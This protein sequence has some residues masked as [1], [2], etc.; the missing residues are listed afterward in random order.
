MLLR[1]EIAPAQRVSATLRVRLSPKAVQIVGEALP[2]KVKAGS[3]VDAQFSV[4]FQVAAAWLDGRCNWQSYERLGGADID[5]LA[6]RIEV[7]VDDNLAVAGAV[8][9]VI[10]DDGAS[11]RVDDPLGEDSRPFS[12]ALLQ[13]KFDDLAQPVYGA[14]RAAQ[15]CAHV[16]SLE[17]EPDASVLIRLLRRS[18]AS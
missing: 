3:I 6:S 10:S 5:A 15:I 16:T 11:V 9:S 1:Q 12:G 4:Y 17:T 7:V 14:D 13:R 8:L 18:S 2:H